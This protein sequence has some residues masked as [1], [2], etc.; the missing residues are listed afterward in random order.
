[1][2][3]ILLVLQKVE[4]PYIQLSK[5]NLDPLIL[6]SKNYLSLKSK[7]IYINYKRLFLVVT[8]QICIL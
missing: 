3:I 8:W 4:I 5:D 1:M 6:T 2:I 7:R